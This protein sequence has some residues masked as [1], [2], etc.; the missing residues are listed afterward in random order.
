LSSKGEVIGVSVA[1]FRGGQNLN[2]AIPSNYLKAL[3]GK[4]SSTKPLGAVKSST[5][6][7][8]ILGGL[9]ERN[10][11]GV[12]GGQLTWATPGNPFSGDYSLSLRN[13]LREN[14]SNVWLCCIN[15]Q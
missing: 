2:F 3:F 5:K 12:V 11:E 8:S 10:T 6:Q 15:Q 4:E 9:G 1:T 14:V 13:Q 7:R